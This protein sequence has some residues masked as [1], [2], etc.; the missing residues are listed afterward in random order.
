MQYEKK[1]KSMD[2]KHTVWIDYQSL[3]QRQLKIEKWKNT[4]I[5]TK[6]DFLIVKNITY[7]FTK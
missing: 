7:I 2:D 4:Q 3:C 1:G 5:I 6:L